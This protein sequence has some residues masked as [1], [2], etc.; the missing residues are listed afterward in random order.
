MIRTLCTL[1][2]RKDRRARKG[3]AAVELAL[4]M[5]ALMMLLFGSLEMGRLY[6][7][8]HSVRYGVDETVRA[9]SVAANYSQAEAE[10]TFH[11]RVPTLPVGETTVNYTSNTVDSIVYVTVAATLNYTIHT[12]FFSFGP[13]QIRSTSTLPRSNF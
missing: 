12:P 5:P 3:V 1:L 11:E 13:L 4:I 9:A 8:W 2:G 10:L 6:F 7:T